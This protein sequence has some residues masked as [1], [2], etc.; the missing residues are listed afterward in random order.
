MARIL[1]L[2][3]TVK[4]RRW[5]TGAWEHASVLGTAAQPATRAVMVVTLATLAVTVA[6]PAMAVM[7]VAGMSLVRVGLEETSEEATVARHR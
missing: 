6:R 2:L 4:I 5:Q 1:T 7:V 3:S